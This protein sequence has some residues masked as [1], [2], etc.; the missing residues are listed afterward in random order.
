MNAVCEQVGRERVALVTGTGSGIGA[1]TACELAKTCRVVVGVDISG[2][3]HAEV[4][5]QCEALGASFVSV[6]AD[7]SDEKSVAAAF[8]VV[9]ELGRLDILVHCAGVPLGAG[10]SRTAKLMVLE[11]W[12]RLIRINLT[13]SFLVCRAAVPHLKRNGWGRIV[14]IGSQTARIPT[15]TTSALYAASKAGVIGFTRALALELAPLG[16]TVNCV[17]PGLTQTRMASGWNLDAHAKLVPLGRMGQAAEVAEA[18]AFIASD[19][20]AYITGTTLDVNGG[21]AM[22]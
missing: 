20:A 3:D 7:V 2:A 14:T 10:R 22:P 1:A 9:E 17:A 18:V 19:A 15:A 11:D 12:D 16:I 5:A 13:G 4:A 6:V 21:T 8:Q